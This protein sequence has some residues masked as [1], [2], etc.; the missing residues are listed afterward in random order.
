ML[1]AELILF[2]NFA[3]SA[4]ASLTVLILKKIYTS[5]KSL[6]NLKSTVKV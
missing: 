2:L 3:F 1:M 4:V 6:G 5:W